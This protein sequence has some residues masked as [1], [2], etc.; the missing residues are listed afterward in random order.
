MF[1]SLIISIFPIPWIRTF[2]FNYCI[3]MV[4][5]FTCAGFIH[6]YGILYTKGTTAERCKCINNVISTAFSKLENKLSK[7]IISQ[8]NIFQF[9][10]SYLVYFHRCSYLAHPLRQRFVS[11]KFINIERLHTDQ[12]Y[13]VAKYWIQSLIFN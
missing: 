4:T 6:T 12:K 3:P 2:T 8:T 10:L 11:I 7:F 9:F 1:S 13:P 5:I